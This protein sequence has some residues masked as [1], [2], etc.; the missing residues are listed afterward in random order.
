MIEASWKGRPQILGLLMKRPSGDCLGTATILFAQ[1]FTWTVEWGFNGYAVWSRS[2]IT[3]L[4]E[5]QPVP[6]MVPPTDD[7]TSW[8]HPIS[9]DV[10]LSCTSK[11][12][13][14]LAWDVEEGRAYL[15]CTRL[16]PDDGS[17]FWLCQSKYINIFF[18]ETIWDDWRNS[19]KSS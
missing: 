14:V 10:L 12:S 5:Y 4:R 9:F 6:M 17:L 18:V 7:W 8:V 13:P 2:T 15:S 3:M 1:S 19:S 16:C 11:L